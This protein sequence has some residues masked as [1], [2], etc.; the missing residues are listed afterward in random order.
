MDINSSHE[1]TYIVVPD[2]LA[3]DKYGRTL[4]EPSF[5]YRQILGYLLKILNEDSVVYLAPANKFDGELYEQ[6][7][8]Y[9]YLKIRTKYHNIYYPVYKE[10]DYIDTYGNTSLLKRYL[11]EGNRWPSPAVD[12]VCAKIHSYR[13]EYC[14]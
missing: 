13:A 7:A 12:L 14:F 3:K 8:A 4:S 5:V 2:G 10:F 11:I 9:N 6:E 1:K